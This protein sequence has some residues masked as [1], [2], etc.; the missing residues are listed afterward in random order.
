[1]TQATAGSGRRVGLI[2]FDQIL[3]SLSNIGA[4]IWVAHAFEPEDFGRFSLIM[5][6]FTVAQVAIR[7]LI[8]T[9][10]VVHPEDADTRPRSILASTFLVGLVAGV[11]CLVAGL[12]LLAADSALAGPILALAVPMPLLLV[13][14]VGRYLGIGRQ[15]PEKSIVL[16]A[17][18]VVLLAGGFGAIIAFDLD[19]LTWLV[20]IWAGS[21]ALAALWV[22]VQYGT[23]A[24]DGLDWVREHWGFSWRSLVGGVAASGTVLL[25]ASLM[26][27][28]SS[29]LAVAAF[30]AATLL[31][32]PST[33]VQTSVSTSAAADIARERETGD[34]FWPHVRRAMMI[35]FVVGVL[36]MAL[37]VFLPD[38]IGRAVLGEAW[39]VVEPL[40]LAVSLKVLLMAG[41]SGLRAALIGR[42]RIQVAMVTDIVSLVL[43]GVCMVVGAALGGAEGALWAMAI[44]TGVTTACWWVAIG[45]KGGSA[46]EQAPQQAAEKAPEKAPEKARPGKH[47]A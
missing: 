42:H 28:F 25:T 21:G 5:M 16:D 15:Q 33:A 34:S 1:M 36:T 23:P 22:L 46:P 26:S 18:W 8:S 2:T 20:A 29:P 3:S 24:G 41:Q 13:H 32:A 44:G 47:R 17:L 45:W 11:L 14:D 7:S 27:L 10:V 35:C 9:T 12:A 30:R 6:V 43:A 39:D 19:S 38:V 31:A 4:L 40:M 37:L